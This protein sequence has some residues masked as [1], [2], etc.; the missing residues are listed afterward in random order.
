MYQLNEQWDEF[1]QAARRVLSAADASEAEV[2]HLLQ[3]VSDGWT[4][5]DDATVYDA[6]RELRHQRATVYVWSSRPC[7]QLNSENS[8]PVSAGEWQ[9]LIDNDSDFREWVKEYCVDG[10]ALSTDCWVVSTTVE[11]FEHVDDCDGFRNQ[12]E[13]M[14]CSAL[15]AMPSLQSILNRVQAG[16]NDT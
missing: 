1:E 5:A 4:E 11:H 13:T 15:A 16:A 2:E 9:Y 14:E 10:V 12:A 7:R 8:E 3:D 6:L